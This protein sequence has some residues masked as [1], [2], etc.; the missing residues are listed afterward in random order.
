MHTHLVSAPAVDP[1]LYDVAI[2]FTTADDR[3]ARLAA[4]LHDALVGCGVSVFYYAS[5]P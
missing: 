3:A 2:S 5:I 1:A 4:E